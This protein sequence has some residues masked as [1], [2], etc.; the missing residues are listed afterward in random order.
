MVAWLG[1]NP[2]S[3]FSLF[4]AIVRG[5][6]AVGLDAF[7]TMSTTHFATPLVLEALLILYTTFCKQNN[8]LHLEAIRKR[9]MYPLVLT[10]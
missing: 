2:F 5:A 4:W 6:T 7:R 10:P 8:A 1:P 3:P 9:E